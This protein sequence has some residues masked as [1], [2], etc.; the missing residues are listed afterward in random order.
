MIYLPN[1]VPPPLTTKEFYVLLALQAGATH[2]YQLKARILNFSL[3]GVD[4]SPGNLYPVVTRMAEEC[5][6]VPAGEAPTDGS[7]RLRRLYEL[8]EEG[9]VRLQEELRRLNHAINIAQNA[10][11]LEPQPLPAELRTLLLNVDQST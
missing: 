6:V 2:I 9:V 1:R 5:W 10:G 11:V 7:G 3:G 4:V 8:S